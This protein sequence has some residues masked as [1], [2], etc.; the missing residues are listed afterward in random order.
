MSTPLARLFHET[1]AL[2]DAAVRPAVADALTLADTTDRDVIWAL[3]R[4][5]SALGHPPSRD[6]D[7]LDEV[8]RRVAHAKLV[9][10]VKAERYVR[11]GDPTW[12]RYIAVAIWPSA[13]GETVFLFPARPAWEPYVLDPSMPAVTLLGRPVA[14]PP[15]DPPLLS[16]L[17]ST[18]LSDRDRSGFLPESVA[19]AG[20]AKLPADTAPRVRA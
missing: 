14:W 1:V 18:N 9:A 10:Q 15:F 4:V 11:I 20:N 17:A 7:D 6:H 2:H 12:T 3:L 19:V 13:Q 8:R 5:V 16:L